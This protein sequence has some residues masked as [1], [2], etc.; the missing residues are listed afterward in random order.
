MEN[1]AEQ[2]GTGKGREAEEGGQTPK[3]ARKTTERRD[4]SEGL[5]S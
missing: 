5:S 4:S 3:A 1:S 2:C